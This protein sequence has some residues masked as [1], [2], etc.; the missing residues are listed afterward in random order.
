MVAQLRRR[1]GHAPRGARGADAP[2][3]AG[4][5]HQKIVAAVTTACAGKAVR[6]DAAFQVLGKRFAYIDLWRVVVALPVELACAAQLKPGLVV[7]GNCLAQQCAL[8]VAR[9]V[10]LGLGGV[11]HTRLSTAA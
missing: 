3:F 8:G 10:E 1:L 11:W 7:L 9:V 5:G 2:A 6:K 4:E